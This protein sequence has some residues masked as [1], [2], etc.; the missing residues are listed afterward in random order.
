M[1]SRLSRLSD[2]NVPILP[3][4]KT[5]PNSNGITH[6]KPTEKFSFL[7]DNIQMVDCFLNLPDEDELP[8]ALNLRRTAAGQQADQ[9]LWQ[10]CHTHPLSYPERHLATFW[11]QGCAHEHA[12]AVII[13]W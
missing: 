11:N 1:F 9:D 2:A 7:L 8:F 12:T 5:S 10:R 6:V 4:Q 13:K 3:L